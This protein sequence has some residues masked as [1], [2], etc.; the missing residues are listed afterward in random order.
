M[1]RVAFILVVLGLFGPIGA[2]VAEPE[3]TLQ[4]IEA[5]GHDQ[6]ALHMIW[7]IQIGFFLEM[8]MGFR[9]ALSGNP[10][11]YEVGLEFIF[12]FEPVPED[13]AAGSYFGNYFK[14]RPLPFD[15]LDRFY[16][17]GDLQHWI[18]VYGGSAFS[19]VGLGLGYQHPQTDPVALAEGMGGMY[20]ELS[21]Q[22]PFDDAHDA[23]YKFVPMFVVGFSFQ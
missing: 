6:S 8:S 12:W 20:F 21:I 7:G 13:N 18:L 23:R 16:L 2:A 11:L 15:F 1:T 19:V 9:G 14:L 4:R 10:D 5:T 17:L 3:T 22:I